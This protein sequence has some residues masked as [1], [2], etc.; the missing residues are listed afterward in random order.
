[1]IGMGATSISDRI[2]YN[3]TTGALLFDVDGSSAIAALQF[4]TLNPNLVLTSTDILVV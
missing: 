3:P 2:I 1:M 4:A